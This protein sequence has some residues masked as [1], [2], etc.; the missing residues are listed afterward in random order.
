MGL[1]QRH[2]AEKASLDHRLQKALLLLVATKTFDQ[3][4]GAHGQKRIGRGPD[5][6]GLKVGKA[7]LRQQGRQLHAARF[8]ITRC[9]EKTSGEKCIHRRLDLGDQNRLAIFIARFVF[10]S[11]AVMW[12]KVL[13]R[14]DARRPQRRI[15]GFPR[16]LGK[17][18]ATRQTFGVQH[19][20]Q[21]ESQVS[22]TEQRLGHDGVPVLGIGSV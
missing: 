4:C 3:V 1:G 16:V 20:I 12:C 18:L 9:V 21:L 6:G 7:G 17:A 2:G 15:E 22:G 19:F 8:K 5:V 11:L 13:F 14:D 10:V